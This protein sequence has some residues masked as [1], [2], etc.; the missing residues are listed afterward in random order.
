MYDGND[1]RETIL[2]LKSGDE[3]AFETLYNLF[4]SRLFHYV[5]GRVRLKE[6]A[7]EIVQEIFVSLWNKRES[8]QINTSLESYLFGAAKYKILSFI[9]SEQVRKKFAA[10]FTL[11]ASAQYDNSVEELTD[12]KDLQITLNEKISELPKKCQT[13]FRMSRM[14][15]EPIPQI[16]EKMN[17]STRTVENYISQAL[18][19]L[20]TSLG[21]LLTVIILLLS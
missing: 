13:A 6:Q 11:F 19:H 16:A 21:E 15:H 17:I 1:H 9:R 2:L 20:R 8:L 18:K 10:E 7:E 3:P 14:E 12:L 4:A 5:Y